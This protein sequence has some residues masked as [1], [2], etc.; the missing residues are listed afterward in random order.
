MAPEPHIKARL[1]Q[2]L[3]GGPRWDYELAEQIVLEYPEAH[4][5]YSHNVV[6]LNLADLHSGGLRGHTEAPAVDE[7]RSSRRVSS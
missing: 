4:G 3:E 7:V 2:L 5:E 1:L 6:R